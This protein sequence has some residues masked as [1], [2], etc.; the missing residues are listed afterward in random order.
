VAEAVAARLMEAMLEP[1]ALGDI[2][3]RV[4]ASVFALDASD[5][6]ELLRFADTAMYASKRRGPGGFLPYTQLAA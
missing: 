5:G 1:L 6:D 2:A 3:V 4:S